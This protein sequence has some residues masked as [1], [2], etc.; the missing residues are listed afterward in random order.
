MKVIL[1][2]GNILTFLAAVYLAL[3]SELF[4]FN[5]AYYSAP[6]PNDQVLCFSFFRFGMVFL[7]A[8][9][10]IAVINSLIQKGYRRELA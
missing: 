2:K 7:G 9:V 8:F 10:L 6:R 4:I 3:C 5:N 1:G